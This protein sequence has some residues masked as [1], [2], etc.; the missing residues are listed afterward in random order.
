MDQ[1]VMN[2]TTEFLNKQ[3]AALQEAIEKK[4]AYIIRLQDEVSQK[5]Q[6]IF[7]IRAEQNN[8]RNSIKDYVIEAVRDREMMQGTAEALAEI[9]D[10]ELTKTVTI[11]AT[12][13]F[14]VE[15]EVPFDMDGDDIAHTLDFSVDS[16]EYSIDDFTVDVH[17][18][19]SSDN[20]S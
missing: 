18:L 12:V 9:C 10:F 1:T 20:I 6:T 8:F 5:S 17:S 16:Y 3:V 14:E 4:D 13:D 19:Q 11:T 2:A 7:T 15:L